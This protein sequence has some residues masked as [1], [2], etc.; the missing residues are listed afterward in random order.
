MV[1]PFLWRVGIFAHSSCQVASAVYGAWATRPRYHLGDKRSETPFSELDT[2][3]LEDR[4][5]NAL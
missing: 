2:R 3:K 1:S 5:G 4:N